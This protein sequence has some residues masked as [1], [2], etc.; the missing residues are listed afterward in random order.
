MP[1]S[2]NRDKKEKPMN[3]FEKLKKE[4]AVERDLLG[5]LK[6]DTGDKP[7]VIA[8]LTIKATMC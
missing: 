8:I 6:V 4:I 7:K 2:K 5:G 1:H 3:I